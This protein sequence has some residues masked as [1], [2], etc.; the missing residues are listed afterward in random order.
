VQTV[1]A[2]EYCMD[3][4]QLVVERIALRDTGDEVL[5]RKEEDRPLVS[6]G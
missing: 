2:G 1:I 3:S 5:E 4:A 6:V